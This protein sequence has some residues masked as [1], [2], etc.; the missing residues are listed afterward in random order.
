MALDPSVLNISGDLEVQIKWKARSAMA[1]LVADA[2]L[3]IADYPE[4]KGGLHEFMLLFQ[5]MMNQFGTDGIVFVVPAG[6]DE[7]VSWRSLRPFMDEIFGNLDEA[8]NS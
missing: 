4:L 7:V 1:S 3:D 5:D 8:I 2:G 6:W